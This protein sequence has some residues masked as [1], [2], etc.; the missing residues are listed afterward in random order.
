MLVS[1][2]RDLRWSET[3]LWPLVITVAA[4]VALAIKLWLAYTTIGTNDATTWAR[5]AATARAVG[6]AGLYRAEVLFNH[7]PFM[8][9]VILLMAELAE[10][11]GSA[12]VFWLRLPAII[13]DLALVALVWRLLGPRMTQTGFR[14][15]LLLLALAPPLIM[16]SGFHG[17]TDPAVIALVVFAVFLVERRTPAALAGIAFGLAL[18]VKIVPSIFAPAIVLY[19]A[20]WRARGAFSLAAAV[21]W[22]IG[23]LPYTLQVPDLIA[24]QVFGYQGNAGQWGISRL[25]YL[26]ESWPELAT[27]QDA[28]EGGWYGDVGSLIALGGV[29]TAAFWMNRPGAKKPD[30]FVQC[31]VVAFLFLGLSPAFGVQYLAWLVPWVVALGWRATLAFYATSGLLLFS[32]YT[33]WSREFPW[34]FADSPAYGWRGPLIA[35]DLL[36]WATVIAIFLCYARV[37]WRIQGGAMSGREV[38]RR[39]PT[40]HDMPLSSGK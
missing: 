33:A 19:L 8:I 29:V 17:N 25:L 36:C 13:A 20:T 28:P 11:T 35:L 5:F 6:G 14:V 37:V 27:N 32:V 31:G 24:R 16:I 26:G 40:E 12:F 15:A 7:P 4:L 23:S 34:Y 9:H 38:A 21:A 18:S 22:L 10:R 2:E 1:H 30:L 3:W 39:C